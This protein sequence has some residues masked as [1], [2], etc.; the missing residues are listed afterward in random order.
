[1]TAADV[2]DLAQRRDALDPQRS[3]IVQAPAGSGK[4][5]LLIQRYLGLLSTVDHAEEI[6]A[7]TFTRKAAGEMR[8]RILQALNDAQSGCEPAT[9]HEALTLQLA[10]AALR[11]DRD[12]GWH[13]SENPS[14]LRIQTIDALCAGLTRQM[15][16]LSRFGAQPD[17]VEDA[18]LLYREAA[19]ATLALV[20]EDAAVADDIESLLSHLDNDVSRVETL[21]VDM[22]ARRD[23]WIRRARIPDRET[24]E[25]ALR[26]VR[27]RALQRLDAAL[28]A[29]AVAE[30]QAVAGYA[31]GNLD[32]G[33]F[34]GDVECWVRLAKVFLTADD[35]WR[36]R[37]IRDEG[38][39]AGKP[40]QP[41]K[42][43]ALELF[44]ALDAAP[45]FREALADMRRLPPGRYSDAQW[46]VL[47]AILRLLHYAVAQ[48]KLVFQSRRQVDFTEVAQGA[49]Q[50]LG[51]EGEPTDL[52]LALDYR[53]RHLLIDEFQDTSISQNELV[54]RLMAGWTAGDGRTLFAV[55]DP[56]QS[57]YRFREAEVGLFLRARKEGIG[58]ITLH[59]V[60]LASNFRSQAGIVDWV[61]AAFARIMPA[62][63]DVVSGAVPYTASI[64]VREALQDAAVT[65]HPLVGDDGMEE[66]RRVAGIVAKSRAGNPAAT[67]AILV[68][69]RG[70]LQHIVPQLK[71]AGLRF[72]AIDIEPLGQRPVVQDLLALTRALAHPGDRVA[73]LALLRAPWCGLT[74]A[75]LHVLA[76]DARPAILWDALRDEVR[77]AGLTAD[78]RDRVLRVRAVLA[79]CIGHRARKPLREQVAGA[80]H[81]LGGPACVDSASALED[82]E[83]FFR[84]LD[85]HEEA[86]ELPDR[87]TFEEGL[88]DLYAAADPAAG[89]GL[90]IMTIHKSKGLEFDVVILPG[91]ARAPRGDDK[92]LFLWTEQPEAAGTEELLLAP[93]HATEDDSDLIYD[94]IRRFNAHKQ[95]LEDGR[96]LY[97]AATRAR[98]RLHLF[99]N[100]K[101][102]LDAEGATVITPPSSKSLLCRLWPVVAPAFEAVAGSYLPQEALPQDA[103]AID[104]A[105]Q[106][107]PAGWVLPAA[108][109]AVQWDAPADA[110]RVQ[111]ALEFSW[112]GE[113]ARHV[114]TVVHR[115]LQRIAEDGAEGWD[116]QRIKALIPAIRAAL[117]AKGV[118][119]TELDDAV[120]RASRAL[121]N[122]VADE[123]GRWILGHQA[124][125]RSEWR[126]TGV[127]G[128]RLAGIVID[129]SFVD[130]GGERW[131]I[132]YKTSV[133]EGADV[134]AFLDNEFERYRGQL[135]RYARMLHSGG[136]QRIRLGLYFPLLGGWREWAYVPD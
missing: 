126:L 90:Q 96:L 132:D 47:A 10:G 40:G 82:A 59:P 26:H 115:W 20:D 56:M 1:M 16:L 134:E 54:A 83:T 13:L 114:G 116:E 12:L 17:S 125:A 78:G 55:G 87:G 43:R 5:E 49:L 120:A 30:L 60:A 24:L 92:R 76:A 117:A 112:A 21:L 11:R 38:F 7:V 64:A 70:H 113:T 15:P 9:P 127:S 19:R 48:L 74:L 31:F 80:W 51:G 50:A 103:A 57:I 34:S 69:S 61:N 89:D 58:G 105:L 124:Q 29:A 81:A 44:A 91:L 109:A 41:W 37:L 94:W 42:T 28:P 102:K 104:Q 118:G 62:V 86:G 122:C 129:R 135:E 106:R 77:I 22:L 85:G 71:A 35:G 100:V 63:E 133:H 75:D 52:A 73:W 121:I 97:V 39:P 18:S 14:R 128:G 108:P 99:G 65:V 98:Q 72:R 2:P 84:Y 110:A 93:I 4:T 27:L 123:R 33:P 66:A 79:E 68:R 45:D 136:E 119:D 67:V 36:K 3:F 101:A 95:H 8:E 111:D 88:Q 23:Q 131:I 130:A 6:I 25:L 46:Q 107:L 53:I 32:S